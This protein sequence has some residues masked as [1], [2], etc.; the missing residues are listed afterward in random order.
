MTTIKIAVETSALKLV[1]DQTSYLNIKFSQNCILFFSQLLMSFFQ[2]AAV[3]LRLFFTLIGCFLLLNKL[4]VTRRRQALHV[5]LIGGCFW[6][7]LRRRFFVLTFRNF[8]FNFTRFL[9]LF[10]GFPFL[11]LLLKRKLVFTGN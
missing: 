5:L 1:S 10:R 7:R 6:F 9:L 3:S 2:R 4:I 11:Y 8:L